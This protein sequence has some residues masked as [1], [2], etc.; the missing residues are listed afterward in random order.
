[1]IPKHYFSD[2]S[3]RQLFEVPASRSSDIFEQARFALT[4]K[5]NLVVMLALIVLA[6]VSLYTQSEYAVIYSIALFANALAMI[7][8]RMK[9]EYATVALVLS[10]FL[11]SLIIYS[12]FRIDGYL[13][14]LEP[15]WSLVLVIYIYFI[16]G[17]ILGGIALLIAIISTSLYF[18]F[19]IHFSIELVSV[20]SP[21]RIG[22]MTLE[23]IICLGL[24]GYLIH[25]FINTN[26]E[27][28]TIQAQLNKEL[29]KEKKLVDQQNSEKTA[30]L[31]EIHHRVKNNLQIITSLLRMQAEEVNSPE[32]RAHFQEAINRVMTMAL[33]HQ[34][35]YENENLSDIDLQ[36]YLEL[37]IGDIIS[38]SNC[39]KEIERSIEVEC[40]KIGAQTL[41]PIGLIITEL[42]TNS[43]KHAFEDM[44][45]GKIS[46]RIEQNS[47][48]SS[49][50]L[51]YSDN[52]KWIEPTSSSFGMSLI[53]TFTEQ[54]DGEMQR[55]SSDSGS[56][57]IFT[58]LHI[59]KS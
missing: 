23:F 33:V 2:M 15:F 11:Y 8:M 56:T 20:I 54:L 28:Q 42:V 36:E 47:D 52:G 18:T 4:W 1:M 45:S 5:V 32:T 3:L 57:F 17:K 14:F 44:N 41:M 58:L 55:S 24:I 34:K 26:N 46:I 38:S 50:Q 51:I 10:C 35:L 48:K 59:D 53:E 37:L 12:Y 25:Q 29:R 22:S 31:Q 19:R 9:R 43:I 30:L 39:K 16:R 6:G 27:A 21:M 7:Y 13:H 40:D 49:L